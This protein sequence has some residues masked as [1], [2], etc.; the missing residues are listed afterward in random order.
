M[1]A[2]AIRRSSTR[3]LRWRENEGLKEGLLVKPALQVQHLF[4]HQIRE[5]PFIDL[6]LAAKFII[7][8][9]LGSGQSTYLRRRDNLLIYKSE[10][11]SRSCP[12]IGKA[13]PSKICSPVLTGFQSNIRI[14]K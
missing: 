9:H 14:I 3:S 10:K 4:L 5:W 1:L 6:I 2:M 7:A 12:A 8:K 13:S 11:T